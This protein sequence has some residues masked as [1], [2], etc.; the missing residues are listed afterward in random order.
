MNKITF[1]KIAG[2]VFIMLIIY[3]CAKKGRP[4]GG[5]IDEQPPKV[6]KA[7]PPNYTINFDQEEIQINFDEY[8]KLEDPRSQII[9]SPP[10]EPR[11]EIDPLSFATKKLSILMPDSLLDNTTYT[12]NFGNSIV[13][14]NEGNPLPYYSYVF[15]T[16]DYLDSL[17]VKGRVRDA[18]SRQVE[19]DISIMLYAL[20]TSYTDSAV[21]KKNPRYIAYAKDS[22]NNF[23]INNLKAGKYKMIAVEDNNRNYTYEP[24]TDKIGFFKGSISVPTDTIYDIAVFKEQQPIDFKRPAQI[25]KNQYLIGYTGTIDST[26]INVD[27]LND[28]DSLSWVIEKRPDSDS[29]NLWTTPFLD[30]DSIAMKIS[31]HQVIDTFTLRP[32]AIEKDSL[33]VEQITKSPLDLFDALSLKP[34]IPLTDI[35]TSKIKTYHK[36]DS[37]PVNFKLDYY[38]YSNQVI[39]SHDK[40]ENTSY[41]YKIM[42]GAFQ[43]W[44]GNDNDTLSYTLKTK[45]ESD[46]G[47]IDLT[48]SGINE[49]PAIVQLVDDKDQVIKSTYL[50]ENRLINFEYVKPGELFVRVIIDRNENQIWDTGNFLE[51]KQPEIIIYS[52]EPIKNRANWDVQQS[53]KF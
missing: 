43:D 33:E 34:N 52:K 46:Y 5:P 17:S 12:I 53:I 7:S 2:L 22:T 10:I 41:V 16:G 19:N 44:S 27:F 8:I 35:D 25:T 29:L 50:K 36:K 20:D 14:N 28:Q 15:S 32:K 49:F 38:S 37:T 47:N 45:K 39:I 42:P 3:A 18:Y 21:Y 1:L 30:R 9:F 6:V 40:H 51:N 31:H 11:P 24:Q 4:D 13:D 23:E 26:A 48:I